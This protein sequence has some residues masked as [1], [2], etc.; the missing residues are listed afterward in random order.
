[1]TQIVAVH[2][3]FPAH[4]HPQADLTRAI[5]SLA[6]MD[7]VTDGADRPGVADGDGQADWAGGPD[8]LGAADGAGPAAG[9]R[10]AGSSRQRALLERLH[11]NAGVDSRHTVF[12]LSD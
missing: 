3:A 12:P 8:P 5:A 1:M 2:S 6:G 11:G 4:R 9:A 10:Q 7:A